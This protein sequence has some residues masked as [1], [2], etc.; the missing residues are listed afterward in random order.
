MRR[1]SKLAAR[2][3][4]HFLAATAPAMTM[5]RENC[6]GCQGACVIFVKRRCCSYPRREGGLVSDKFSV[7]E[8]VQFKAQD[9]S[10]VLGM[11]IGWQNIVPAQAQKNPSGP[12]PVAASTRLGT[13]AKCERRTTQQCARYGQQNYRTYCC[14]GPQGQTTIVIR[15]LSPMTIWCCSA[16]QPPAGVSRDRGRMSGHG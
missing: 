8:S 10:T 5:P 13:C 14:A 12:V 16:D 3:V 11:S 4:V 6:E 15:G 2:K 7:R 9:H 1:M